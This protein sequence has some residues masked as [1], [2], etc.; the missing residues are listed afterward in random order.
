MKKILIVED[1]GTMRLFIKMFLRGLQ[2][3]SITEAVDGLD[4]LEKIDQDSFDLIITDINMPR[5]NGLQLIERV[6][7]MMGL[8]MPIIILT[9]R[10]EEGEME[11]GLLLGADN[12]VTKPIVGPVLTSLVM[13]HLEIAA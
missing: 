2:R 3:V 12:Y 4:A 8:T 13:N 11:R 5:L 1:S 9:T 6:R 7:R 10:G